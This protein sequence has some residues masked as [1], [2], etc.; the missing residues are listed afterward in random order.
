MSKCNSADD[1]RDQ[2]RRNFPI[3][4]EKLDEMRAVFGDDVKLTYANE[5][6]KTIG[7]KM[8]GV[9]MY[10]DQWQRLT[11]LIEFDKKQEKKK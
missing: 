8:T 4:A 5:N 3:S 1:A 10:T 11:A 2:N 7:K 9:L 6:G